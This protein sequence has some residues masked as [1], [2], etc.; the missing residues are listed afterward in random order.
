M[1]R[2]DKDGLVTHEAGILVPYLGKVVSLW[3]DGEWIRGILDGDDLNWRKVT[4]PYP[5]IR[6]A[7]QP[8]EGEGVL[9]WGDLFEDGTDPIYDP[10]YDSAAWSIDDGY[11]SV[12]ACELTLHRSTGELRELVERCGG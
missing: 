7:Y 6:E 5:L 10:C 2:Y 4:I 8:V 11:H 1:I 9:V 3:Q 12:R